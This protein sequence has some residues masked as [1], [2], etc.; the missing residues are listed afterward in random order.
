MPAHIDASIA[1]FT[2]LLLDAVC[3][4]D[5]SGRFVYASAACERIFGY[6][7]AELIGT[8]MIDLVLPADRARTLAAAAAV[9]KG[10]PHINF[11]NRYVRKDGTVAHIMWSARWSEADQ[12]RVAVARDVTMVKRADA[13]REALYTLSEASL[14]S[15]DLSALFRR[16]HEIIRALLPAPGL[17]V[18]LPDEQQRRLGIVFDADGN[19]S[20][21]ALLPFYEHVFNTD[22]S[23]LV[24]NH[25]DS[26]LPASLQD[27]AAALAGSL[28]VV[29]LS[30]ADGAI[31][32]LALIDGN[33]G[34]RYNLSDLE[35]LVFAGTQVANA[36]QR[37]QLLERL[38]FLA[39]HDDLTRLPNRRLFHDRLNTALARAHRQ[40]RRLALLFVDLD[41]F[42]Q[43]ND[44]Y[45]HVYG[46]RLLRQVAARIGAAVRDSD[47]VARLGGDEFVVLLEDIAS[48]LDTEAV[49]EK[50]RL[51]LAPQFDLGEGVRLQ[52]SASI[53]SAHYP[54]QAS[55]I[56]ALIGIADVSMYAAK[57]LNR[58]G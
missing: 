10:H 8:P 14:A 50:I 56:D 45:G 1:N 48:P 54:D 39:M 22:T 3:M 23:L 58:R 42:K 35:L 31:G 37:K 38:Q 5:A 46:D 57:S 24:S 52:V 13:M 15:D 30:T 51:A 6:T 36:V 53:G 16:C 4:V 2:D 29:P 40:Q 55:T 12:L 41:R 47:T 32:V 11:E 20:D 26:G 18:V 17:C 19:G 7:Q 9:M 33:L 27:A 34:V 44:Q 49:Q 25:A 28:L 21:A 43:V